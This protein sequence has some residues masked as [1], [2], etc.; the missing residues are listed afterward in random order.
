MAEKKVKITL[1]FKAIFCLLLAAFILLASESGIFRRF[2]AL[3]YD[4]FFVLTVPRPPHPAII[5]IEITDADIKQVGAWP[6]KRTWHALMTKALSD[7]G[8]K[9]IFFDML[10]PDPSVPSEDEIFEAAIKESG[11]VYLPFAL[12]VESISMDTAV[13]PNRQFAQWARGLGSINIHPDPDGTI[14]RLRAIYFD[15]ENIK[16]HIALRMAIDYNRYAVDSVDSQA[17]ILKNGTGDKLRINFFEKNTFLLNWYG[18]WKKTFKHYSYLDVLA[19]YKA[20]KDG[21]KPEIDVRV[22]DK[23]ICLVAAT[24][25]GLPDIKSIPIE[26]VYPGVG[27][28]A[29]AVSNILQR[30]IIH[31]SQLLWW[32]GLFMLFFMSLVPLVLVSGEKLAHE[33]LGICFFVMGYLFIVFVLFIHGYVLPAIPPILGFFVSYFTISFYNMWRITKEKKVFFN[34]AITDGLTR[35]HNIGYFRILLEAAVD[36]AKKD[37]SLKLCL[38]MC[39]IDHFKENY[40]EIHQNYS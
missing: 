3:L 27:I 7:M 16:L 33:T 37:S 22:F 14:R 30:S 38:L 24:A 11:N 21:R 23:S 18:L 8:A 29:T 6:W 35:L 17:L 26:S 4:A 2:E 10:F 5:I 19:A 13:L 15:R 25:V 32:L 34:M 1:R 40:S 12:E 31:T 36:L 28:I 20:V 9:A 39:D